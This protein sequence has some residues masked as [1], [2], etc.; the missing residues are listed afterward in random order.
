MTNIFRDCDLVLP[1]GGFSAFWFELGCA[2][3]RVNEHTRV[4]GWSAGVLAAI[5]LLCIERGP[6]I[7]DRIIFF[8]KVR[9]AARLAQERAKRPI[10]RMLFHFLDILLPSDAHLRCSGRLLI[11]VTTTS[12]SPRAHSHWH[13]RYELIRC[14]IASCHIPLLTSWSLLETHYISFDGG[15]SRFLHQIPTPNAV[16]VPPTKFSVCSEM[17]AFWWYLGE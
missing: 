5:A 8:A 1:G 16:K 9:D 14:A 7:E 13:S 3:D 10:E 17:E 6:H 11:L 4:G 15:L 12:L 2:Y